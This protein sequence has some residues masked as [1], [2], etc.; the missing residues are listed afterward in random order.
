M[1]LTRNAIP[2]FKFLWDINA[3]APPSQRVC[4]MVQ[5]YLMIPFITWSGSTPYRFNVV[6]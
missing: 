5:Y 4:D 2:D 6:K 3:V 1:N